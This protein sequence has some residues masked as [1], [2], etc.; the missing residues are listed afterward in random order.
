MRKVLLSSAAI[1]GLALAAS[2]AMAQDGGVKLGLGGYFMGYGAFVDQD[3]AAGQE[4]NEFDLLRNTEIH[5]TGETTLDNGLTVGAHFEMEADGNNG[6]EVEESYLYMSGQW[7]RVNLGAEDGAAFLLQV[8]APS[9]DSNVDGIRTLIQP[10][11][12]TVAGFAQPGRLD[13]DQNP[14]GYADKITYL[15]PVLNGFQAGL[16]FTPD[17]GNLVADG[18][19]A[20]DAISGVREDDEANELQEAYEAAVRYEGQWD[21]LGFAVGA[22]YSHVDYD[23]TAA[24]NIDDWKLWN[25]G[26]DLDYGPFGLG[27]AY[28]HDDNMDRTTF[29]DIETLVVGIDYTTGPFKLGASWY[30]QEAEHNTL[31]DE[32]TDRYTGGVAYTY[33][34]GMTF[35]G[36]ISYIEHD[37]LAS[38]ANDDMDATSILLGTQV[39]F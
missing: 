33:G 12:Y 28:L 14:T 18:E 26:V 35:R 6:M 15:T 23:D 29:G 1:C 32:E 34:P 19:F 13:Y 11:N 16:S 5:F 27:V 39:L 30:N 38:V 25:V 7:G 3:E 24:A 9:A 37:N 31:T 20:D 10:V 8:A 4:V 36:S 21:A 2:P 17:T 22:G